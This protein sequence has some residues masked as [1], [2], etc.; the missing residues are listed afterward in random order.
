MRTLD[1][2]GLIA[3]RG[4][5]CDWILPDA[6]C[7]LSNQHFRI[8]WVDGQYVLTDTSSNGVYHNH[9]EHPIG[10]GGSVALA[11]GD[12]LVLGDYEMAVS[13]AQA[14]V[15]AAVSPWD[16]GVFQDS[17][18]DP[19][20]VNRGAEP[21]PG[22]R[23]PEA[24]PAATHPDHVP[25]DQAYFQPP[26]PIE[27]LPDDWLESLGMPAPPSS[28]GLAPFGNAEAGPAGRNAAP[29]P[30]DLDDLD[31]Q[32]LK[33]NAAVQPA[34]LGTTPA[35]DTARPSPPAT[36]ATP[37]ASLP[38][39]PEPAPAVA[40]QPVSPPPSAAPSPS[41]AEGALLAAFLE[42]AGL[43]P[44][45]LSGTDPAAAMRA[46]GCIY[47]QMV[48]GLAGLLAVR[49]SLKNEFRIDRTI[50]GARNNNPL[51]FAVDPASTAQQLLEPPRP[52]FLRGEDAVREG[53]RDIQQHELATSVG[54]HSALSALLRRFDPTTLK[55][56]LDRQSLLAS[57]LPA[58][59]RARYWE[60]YEDLHKE[61]VA[62]A[63]DDF[64]SLFGREFAQAYERQV[65]NLS[66]PED[67]P[68]RKA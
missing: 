28:G 7:I 46:A 10:R 19:F 32:A 65:R 58:A 44:T 64:Q 55:E 50:I 47:R 36:P 8:S 6:E 49:A 56:R 27:E 18:G 43:P 45:A 23:T 24:P 12:S 62:E 30:F 42:G 66:A 3:G 16:E 1:R 20:Q 67:S 5:S 52:G 35:A 17:F 14:A 57:I 63:E 33:Q 34:P 37:I 40:A 60:L 61:I 29:F 2:T 54:M 11:D 41:A 53:F 39:Q 25:L 68:L 51:K 4:N 48:E 59:R 31:P 26:N 13:L 22:L 21:F 15:P 38:A 9:A